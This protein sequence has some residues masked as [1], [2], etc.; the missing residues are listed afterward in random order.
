MSIFFISPIPAES[1]TWVSICISGAINAGVPLF[2]NLV[3]VLH[4]V[5]LVW[6]IVD[7]VSPRSPNLHIIGSFENKS[8]SS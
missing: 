2:T 5:I 7:L 6:V 8:V 4:T 3:R 1:I